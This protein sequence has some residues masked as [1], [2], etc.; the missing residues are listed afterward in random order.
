MEAAL[1][2]TVL[3]TLAVAALAVA[4]ADPDTDTDTDFGNALHA[5]GVYGHQD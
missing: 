4:H 5:R 1:W 2:T 3:P